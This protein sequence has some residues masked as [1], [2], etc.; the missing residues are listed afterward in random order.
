VPYYALASIFALP[1]LSEGSPNVIL[2][3]MAAGLPIASTNVGGVPEILEDGV[4]GLLVPA[5][6]PPALA[7]ALRRLLTSEDLR[8]QLA[9][10]GRRQAE[11]AHTLQAYKRE[12]TQFYVDLLSASRAK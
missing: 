6:D 7:E 11:T 3:A 12:L 1:S 2:E 10:A 5:H 9:S 4:T 8:A